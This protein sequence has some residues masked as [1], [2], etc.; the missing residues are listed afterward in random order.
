MFFLHCMLNILRY[1]K[2]F[3]EIDESIAL[4]HDPSSDLIF[5]G[6]NFPFHA[7]YIFFQENC[8][9]FGLLVSGL[10]LSQPA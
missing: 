5:L 7:V 2:I 3:C 10:S 6:I 1:E 4:Q 9:S 8:V